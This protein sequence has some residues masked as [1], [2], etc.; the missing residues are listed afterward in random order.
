VYLATRSR[1]NIAR[2]L[3]F[4]HEILMV[5]SAVIAAAY[6]RAIVAAGFQVAIER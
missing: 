5:G 4:G 2:Y 1:R 3:F 6:A